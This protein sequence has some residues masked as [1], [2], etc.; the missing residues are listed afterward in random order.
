MASCLQCYI[1]DPAERAI[2]EKK[3][4]QIIARAWSS[5]VF[6]ARTFDELRSYLEDIEWQRQAYA[7][8]AVNNRSNAQSVERPGQ[9]FEIELFGPLKTRHNAA[10]S[11]NHVPE[12]SNVGHL[13]R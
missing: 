4:A 13:P 8:S 2:T 11:T 3:L 12:T 9:V 5:E 7:V 6:E 1:D 10:R